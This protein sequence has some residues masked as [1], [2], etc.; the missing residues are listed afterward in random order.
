[1]ER[2]GLESR[3]GLDAVVFEGRYGVPS[4]LGD[5]EWQILA[6]NGKTLRQVEPLRGP[7]TAPVDEADELPQDDRLFVI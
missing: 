4:S 2:V 1:M 3:V 7:S 6:R 5:L